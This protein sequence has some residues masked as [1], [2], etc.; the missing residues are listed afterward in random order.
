MCTLLSTSD[1]N[2]FPVSS[3]SPRRHRLPVSSSGTPQSSFLV[4]SHSYFSCLYKVGLLGYQAALIFF[5]CLMGCSVLKSV[6]VS[7]SQLNMFLSFLCDLCSLLQTGEWQQQPP[8]N[9]EIGEPFVSS[10]CPSVSSCCP[11]VSFCCLTSMQIPTILRSIVCFP[12]AHPA[13]VWLSA[14]LA[15]FRGWPMHL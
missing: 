2:F 14:S 1:W 8:P 11:S 3:P 9:P 12:V 4:L 10:S 5:C 7:V 6:G 13:H 15:I